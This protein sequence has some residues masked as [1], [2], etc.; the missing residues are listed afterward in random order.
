VAEV[1]A[2]H[3]DQI[4]RYGVSHGVRDPGLLE[5]ALFRPQIGY[6]ADPIEE[7][8]ALWE[9]MSQNHPFADGNKRRPLQPPIRSSASTVFGSPPMLKSR[10]ISWLGSMKKTGLTS[11]TS[12]SLS[13]GCGGISSHKPR[14]EPPGTRNDGAG[15]FVSKTTFMWH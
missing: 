13:P 1:L 7:A 4:E 15:R 10:M 14:D 5:V 6:Y 9:S 3:A 11:L 8:A 12:N 2:M